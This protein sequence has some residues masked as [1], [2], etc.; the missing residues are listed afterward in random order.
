MFTAGEQEYADNILN[1]IDPQN[2][3]FKRRLY[4]QDCIKVDDFYIKD[5]D[6]FLDR[7]REHMCIVDNSILSFAF[8]LDNGIPIN[9]F[10]GNE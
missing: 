4:R 6:V 1:Y 8:D 5:L 9:S 2:T 7:D 10:V 3:I